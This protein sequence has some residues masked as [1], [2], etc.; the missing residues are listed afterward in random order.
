MAKIIITGVSRGIGNSLTKHLLKEDHDVLGV[1]R[2]NRALNELY[3]SAKSSNGSFI[4]LNID[5][6][7]KGFADNLI[8]C[9]KENNFNPDVMINNAAAMLNKKI[10]DVEPKDFDFLFHVNVKVPFFLIRDL[11]PFFSF[12]SHIV[13]ISSMGG[14]QGSI[15]CGTDG[16]VRGGFSRL[17]S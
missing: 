14:F 6:S 3:E 2:N 11:I 9:I 7:N 4:P 10:I 13:N 15:R 8:D 12:N 16:D 1:S 5:I 17:Y